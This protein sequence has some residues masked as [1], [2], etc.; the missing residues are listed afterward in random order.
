MRSHRRRFGWL[1]RL[2][3]L[4][5]LLGVG[6]G[7]AYGYLLHSYAPGLRSEARVVPARVHDQLA[8]QGATYV[9]LSQISVNLQHA[10]VAIEDHRFYAHPGVDPLGLLRAVWINLRNEHLDQ[11][12]STLEEQLVK[13]AIVGDQRTV[14]AKLRIMG[15]AWAIDQEF[16]KP[17][18]LEQ[19]LNA[20]YYGRGAYGTEAAAHVYFNTDAAD[21]TITQSAFLAA[22]PQAPS[23]YG[24]NPTSPVVKQR[25]IAVLQ[26]MEKDNFITADQERIAQ[27]RVEGQPV[28]A[29]PTP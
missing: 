2:F 25:W 5:L 19:Y 24:S 16:T 21:L 7:A 23:V 29:F 1:R 4:V 12:G 20:A 9:P 11:G 14:R 6:C 27:S 10:I 18:I 17:Q 8:A 22:M 3:V 26:N 15:L 13:R 28:F